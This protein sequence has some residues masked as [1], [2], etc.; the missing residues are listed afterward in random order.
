MT[1]RAPRLRKV[2]RLKCAAPA[3][4]RLADDKFLTFNVWY[5]DQL[6]QESKHSLNFRLHFAFCSHYRGQS[7]FWPG[8]AWLSTCRF[9]FHII[10]F[11]YTTNN[12]NLP[13]QKMVPHTEVN[14]LL[15]LLE[16]AGL[17]ICGCILEI[18]GLTI[19]GF[20]VLTN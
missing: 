10:L 17:T 15:A 5:R 9:V 13:Q 3:A 6:V 20:I 11:P 18:A 7:L 4:A 16:S 14:D 1:S 2:L 19:C 8:L 12:N